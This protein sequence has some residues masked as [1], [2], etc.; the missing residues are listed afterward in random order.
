MK[1]FNNVSSAVMAN[2]V[3]GDQR[4]N[5]FLCG[6]DAA[7]KAT[8]KE[9]AVELDFDPVD[10]GPLKIARYLEPFAMRSIQLAVK[11][12]WGSHCAFKMMKR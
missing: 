10:A 8:V 7:A 2:L 6:D 4:A 5:M 9:L 11:E 1:A 12:G 3:F